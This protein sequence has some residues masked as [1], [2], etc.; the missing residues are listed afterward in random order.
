MAL[1]SHNFNE[2][3]QESRSEHSETHPDNWEQAL[4]ETK[5]KEKKRKKNRNH[6]E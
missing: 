3:H 5:K 1:Y 2:V 6:Q 4:N